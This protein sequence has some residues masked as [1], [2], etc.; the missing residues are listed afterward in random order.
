MVLERAAKHK[1]SAFVEI[2]QD[3]NVFN[4]GAFEYAT[5]NATRPETVVY[6]EHGK[7]L[8]FG[9]NR[10]KGIR[11]NGLNPEVV[12]LGNGMTEDDLLFH[13]EKSPEPTLAYLL[14]RMMQPEFPEPVGIFRD[15]ERPCYDELV[16]EQVT[17]ALSSKGTGDLAKLFDSEDSWTV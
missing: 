13:D 2:Y 8:V 7:P 14:S 3:C 5:D 10:D 9:K 11:L 6:L 1:G 17:T 16:L 4:S 12:T 15:V